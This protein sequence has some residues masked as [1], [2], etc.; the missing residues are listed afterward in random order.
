MIKRITNRN[1]STLTA[2]VFMYA[3]QAGQVALA[4]NPALPTDQPLRGSW[5]YAN[6]QQASWCLLACTIQPY[7]RQAGI[8]Q[9]AQCNH[10]IGKLVFVSL[11]NAIM[12]QVSW[13]S[14][15]CTTQSC[16]RQAGICQLAQR[17]HAIGKLVFVSLHNAIMQ[18]VSWHSFVCTTQSYNGQVDICQLAQYYHTTGNLVLVSFHNAVI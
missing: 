5:R 9:F 2:L 11:H 8:R 1:R 10:I 13:H 7:N 3:G 14:F 18:Q 17:S 12:Q 4:P 15:V 6:M 16:N